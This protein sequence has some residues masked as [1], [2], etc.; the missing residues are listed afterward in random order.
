MDKIVQVDTSG[1]QAQ[2]W[3]DERDEI[4]AELAEIGSVESDSELTAAGKL[5]TRASKH[6]KVL[7]KARV[8]VKAPVIKLGKDIEAHAKGLKTELEAG[9][10]RV[11]KLN[12]DYATK[13]ANEAEAQRQRIAEEEA[14]K[15]AET[16][17]ETH[18]TFGG[19]TVEVDVPETAPTTVAA[20]LPTG[21]VHTG[22]NAMV[23]VWEYEVIDPR[24]VPDEYKIIDTKKINAHKAYKTKMGETPEIPGIK[25]T[26]RMDARSR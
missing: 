5:Q 1:L 21:R 4:L 17:T 6:L 8:A 12:G 23:K 20:P 19:M 18:A 14:A 3:I 15:A 26:S 16:A 7:E 2:E 25:F 13:I 24:L 11:K 22:A 10:A 9:A